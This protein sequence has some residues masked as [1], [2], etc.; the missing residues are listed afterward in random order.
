MLE[1][2]EGKKIFLVLNVEFDKEIVKINE[3]DV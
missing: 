2:C 1:L 3:I